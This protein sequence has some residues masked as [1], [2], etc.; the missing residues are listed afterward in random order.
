MNAR[1]VDQ[2]G[3]YS[4]GAGSRRGVGSSV[5]RF[6]IDRRPRYDWTIARFVS[7]LG[8]SA[9]MATGCAIST[10]AVD[11]PAPIGCARASDCAVG[12]TCIAGTCV[13]STSCVSSRMCPGL[14][15]DTAS[16]TCVECLRDGDCPSMAECR[17]GVCEVVLSCH[18]DGDCAAR[19]GVCD[20]TTLTCVACST[21]ADCAEP[22][23]CAGDHSCVVRSMDAGSPGD[24]SMDAAGTIDVAVD[25]TLIDAGV[26]APAADGE[27]DAHVSD[28]FA[29]DD[30]V[31]LDAD[32]AIV[33]PGTWQEIGSGGGVQYPGF[34]D[35]SPGV[36]EFFALTGATGSTRSFAVFDEST[37]PASGT[38]M[39][40]ADPGLGV[41]G[42]CASPA[43]VGTSL[44]LINGTSVWTGDGSTGTFAWRTLATGVSMTTN[45]QTAH[46]AATYIYAV[47]DDDRIVV[48]DGSTVAYLPFGMSPP[49]T[50]ARIVY[51]STTQRLYV[52]PNFATA[53]LYE[54]YPFPG[55][56]TPPPRSL[57]P[58]PEP[59]F[60]A[61]FC[62]D[63]GYEYLYAAGGTTGTRIWRYDIAADVWQPLA[64]PLPFDHDS[65]GACTVTYD[66]WLYVTDNGANMARIQ[67]R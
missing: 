3:E 8:V 57:A 62:G 1:P 48:W 33:L 58:I 37:G 55:T 30:V 52:A 22:A 64:P 39:T 34:S 11:A 9:V 31:S 46:D 20:P 19:G 25:A 17:S 24:G 35:C 16:M 56:G 27:T 61:T 59:R 26:D 41:S 12:T 10:T 44:F 38:W 32:E 66:G 21:D 49:A 2:I 67:L 5:E 23:V 40:L 51:N 63:A 14:V 29:P 60:T 4:R 13:M 7:A 50:Y 65:V 45:S 18:R 28:A 42:L 15:C 43:L 47:S 6:A 53:A 36:F 54:V